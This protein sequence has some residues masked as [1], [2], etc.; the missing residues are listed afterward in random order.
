MEHA[1]RHQVRRG[2]VLASVSCA[3]AF[4]QLYSII[5]SYSLSV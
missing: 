2:E 5:A 4:V 1:G 3:P